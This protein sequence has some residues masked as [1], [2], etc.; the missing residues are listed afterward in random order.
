MK[1][2]LH[3]YTINCKVHAGRMAAFDAAAKAA[4]LRYTRIECVNGRAFDR[5]VLCSM[6]KAG[7]LRASAD[8][9]PIEVAIN[10]SHAAAWARIAAGRF[11]HG[12]VLEDD[13][14]VRPDFKAALDATLDE[15]ASRPDTAGFG[16]LFLW[17]GK[18]GGDQKQ[19]PVLKNVPG[20]PRL[21]VNAITSRFNAG[22][23]AYVLSRGFARRLLDGFFPMDV[24]QD[25]YMGM[26]AR[27]RT[28]PVLT[29]RMTY[30]RTTRCYVSPV[31]N[32][33]CGGE[34]G[35][36]DTTQGHSVPHVK[37]Y[38]CTKLPA[39]PASTLWQSAISDGP[40]KRLLLSK[41]KQ[42]SR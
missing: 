3:V 9:S 1:R 21:A 28:R 35:T 42:S 32:I 36:G 23:V 15:L 13:A 17:N 40:L 39:P 20:F 22:G 12:L 37:T 25:T 2:G 38:R 26:L 34:W 41:V 14:R 18:W 27:P 6:H 29:L 10:L 24:A 8:L 5:Q 31:L 4:G 11:S 33:D 30:D 16:A 7:L 19:R